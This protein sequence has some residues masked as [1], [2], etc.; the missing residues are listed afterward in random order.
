MIDDA[1]GL[2]VMA[3]FFHPDGLGQTHGHQVARFFDPQ[4]HGR[5]AVEFV[6]VVAGPPFRQARPLIDDEGRI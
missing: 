6:G 1:E 2:D 5:G 4:T 3:D